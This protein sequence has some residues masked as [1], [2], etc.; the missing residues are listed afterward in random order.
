MLIRNFESEGHKYFGTDVFQIAVQGG[1]LYIRS[2]TL[3]R[4]VA[5]DLR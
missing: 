2:E 1:V 5:L 4:K 3:F